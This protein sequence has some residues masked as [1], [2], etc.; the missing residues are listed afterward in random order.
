MFILEK[1]EKSKLKTTLNQ[2]KPPQ[3]RDGSQKTKIYLLLLKHS[4]Q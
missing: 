3:L 1:S 4:L 2:K